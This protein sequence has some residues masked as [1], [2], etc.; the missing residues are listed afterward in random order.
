MRACGTTC[1]RS[2]GEGS[3]SKVTPLRSG[4][5]LTASRWRVR[6]P[7]AAEPGPVLY[8]ARSERTLRPVSRKRI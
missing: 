3:D 1:C 4:R 8:A 2:C 5:S 6:V 7:V